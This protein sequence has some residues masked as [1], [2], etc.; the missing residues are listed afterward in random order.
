MKR[1]SAQAE[2][3]LVAVLLLACVGCEVDSYFDP[4]KTGR[5]EHTPTTIPILERID[6]IEREQDPWAK[7]TGVTPEDLLPSDLTY[8]LSPGDFISVEIFELLVPGQ[9]STSQRRIDA[10]GNFRLPVIGDVRAAGLTP[11]E[12]QDELDRIVDEQVIRSPQINVVVEEG[13]GFQYT[14]YG[15]VAGTGLYALRRA[16]IRLL[17]ALAQA[18]GVPL[19]TQKIYVIRQVPLA[20]EVIFEP[21]RRR[22]GIEAPPRE[23]PPV[24]IEDLIR[25]LEE[26]QGDDVTPGMFHQEGGPVIDIDEL[27]PVRVPEPPAV[28]IDALT[29]QPAVQPAEPSGGES[30]IYIEERGEWVPVRAEAETAPR[31]AGAATQPQAE[32]IV[33]RIIEIPYQKLKQGDGS[34]NIVIRPDDRVY[35][36]EPAAGVVYIDGEIA[37]PGVYSLPGIG[38]L[39]LSR[40]IAAA[41]GPGPLAIPQRVDLTRIVGENREATLRLNLAAIRQK[42]EPDLYLKPDDHIIIGTSWIATPIAI[43]RSGLRMTYGFGF[44]LDR[45]FGNDVFGAPPTNF[46]N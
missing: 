39:T 13:A 43:F 45:N 24:D 22:E 14:M 42:T 21:A 3:S 40:L 46:R 33:E 31:E 20:D 18:G 32:L 28:D 12:F 8:R 36:R 7:A 44:L 4:S 29:T 25:Q 11:Q 2:M 30:F 10:A 5:F 41:G 17:D 26:D 35:V 19:T 16:D 38:R 34:Y 9:V 23:R 6:V 37:R 1:R 15:A 27:E